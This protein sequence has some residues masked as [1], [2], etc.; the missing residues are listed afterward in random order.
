MPDIPKPPGSSLPKDSF[1]PHIQ[2]SILKAQ[3][4]IEI[5]GELFDLCLAHASSE[6][7]ELLA[8]V[9]SLLG[10]FANNLRS[11]LN[12]TMRGVLAR[13]VLPHLSESKRKK[14]NRKLDFPYA[15]TR[16]AFDG[17]PLPK[18][19]KTTDQPLYKRLLRFQ[20]FNPGSEWLGHLMIL[21]NKDKHVILNEVRSPTATAFFALMPDGT[22]LKE[23]WFVGDKLV[24]FVGGEPRY[25]D[26]P[27]YFD[28]LRAFA[29]PR[30][31]WSL[32]LIPMYLRFSLD[33]IDFTRTSPLKVVHILAAIEALYNELPMDPSA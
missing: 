11:A 32:Y 8:R 22:P 14:L 10:D 2:Q 12:Y 7:P 21:S 16:A 15:K 13:E 6:D 18:V 17:K 33:L 26:L 30:H 29:T 5:S 20:P 31:T 9:G 19:L 23:P 27:Y 3:R 28:P 25:A 1:P 4:A 24:V